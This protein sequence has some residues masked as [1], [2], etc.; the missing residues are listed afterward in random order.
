MSCKFDVV[1]LAARTLESQTNRRSYSFT[2]HIEMP[3]SLIKRT[4]TAG[5]HAKF[6]RY[7]EKQARHRDSS[8][9]FAVRQ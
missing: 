1:Q 2:I 6:S 7:H 5:S 8:V 9:S 3:P 4:S